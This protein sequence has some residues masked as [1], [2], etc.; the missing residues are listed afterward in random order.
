MNE[1][2]SAM[3]ESHTLRDR[4]KSIIKMRL[5]DKMT[6]KE[7]GKTFKRSAERARCIYKSAIRKSHR[8]AIKHGLIEEYKELNPEIGTWIDEKYK[9]HLEKRAVV[10]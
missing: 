4:E 6:Y 1:L 2:I 9:E 10:K 3:I 8:I 5:V 7:I